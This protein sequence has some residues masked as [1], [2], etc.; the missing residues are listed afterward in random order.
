MLDLIKEIPGPYFL[1]LYTFI[2]VCVIILTKKYAEKDY[3]ENFEIPEPSKITPLDIAV[4]TKG[5]KGAIMVSVF[6]L[7]RLKKIKINKKHTAIILN[8]INNDSD[9]LNKLETVILNNL[10]NQ[11]Q[12]SYF[13]SAKSIKSVETIIQPNKNLLNELQLIPGAEIKKRYW[14]LTLISSCLLFIIGFTKLYLGISRHKPVA[15]LVILMIIS[16]IALFIIV[17][18]HKVKITCLGRKFL[19]V[20]STRFEWLKKDKVESLLADNNLLYGIALFGITPFL[21][22]HIGSDLEAFAASSYKSSGCGSTG[23]SGGGS[24]CSGGSSCGGG[25]GGC[26]GD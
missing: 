14:N 18:P 7:W 20:S 6:N 12:Y 3:T 5:I 19:A 16:L 21:G 24:G 2:S 11:K 4:L 25:C 9:G 10:G 15:F 26:G 13:F 1:L 8:K 17:K 23:C 22:S